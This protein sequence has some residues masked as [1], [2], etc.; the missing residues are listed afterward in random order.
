MVRTEGL[1]LATSPSLC[2]SQTPLETRS[3][4]REPA[5]QK[6]TCTPGHAAL[7]LGSLPNG[8]DLYPVHCCGNRNPAM[9]ALCVSPCQADCEPER[10]QV[11]PTLGQPKTLGIAEDVAVCAYLVGKQPQICQLLCPRTLLVRVCAGSSVQ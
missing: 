5:L 2:S 7:G 9:Q 3:P 6:G 10:G 11:L 8:K 4:H 1:S